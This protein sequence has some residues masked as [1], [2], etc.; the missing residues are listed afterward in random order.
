MGEFGRVKCRAW[1][2]L[3]LDWVSRIGSNEVG[4]G[5]ERGVGKERESAEGIRVGFELAGPFVRFFN[6]FKYQKLA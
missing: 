6:F 1:G 5:L 3:G 4:W 2:L